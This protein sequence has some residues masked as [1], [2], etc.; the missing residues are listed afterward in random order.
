M[1]MK[2]RLKIS[3]LSISLLLFS[4]ALL[5]GQSEKGAIV[6]TVTDSNGSVVSSATVTIT[7]LGN[8]TSQTYTTN[9]DGLYEA[10]FLTPST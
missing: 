2:I 5:L 4:P 8:N 1:N 9:S 3:F 10:P 6:G 7:N